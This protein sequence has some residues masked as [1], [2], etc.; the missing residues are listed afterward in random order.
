MYY[1]TLNSQP[2]INNDLQT[3][4]FLASLNLPTITAEQNDKLISEI[5]IGELYAAI[6]KLKTGKSPGTDG[7]TSEWY[8]SMR[9][10]LAPA[11]LKAFNW[12]L[13]KKEI[14]TSR[15][16][17]IISVYQKTGKINWIVPVIAQ[18]VY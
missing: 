16:N 7:F 18:S 2:E 9:E 13:Q 15:R 17:A 8:R 10:Q 1:K 3:E 4:S 11:L 5:Q 12:V 14:P 6:S